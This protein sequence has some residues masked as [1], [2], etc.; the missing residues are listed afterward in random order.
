VVNKI[1]LN[2]ESASH[3]DLVHVQ[4]VLRQSVAVEACDDDEVERTRTRNATV[5][6]EYN[7]S[8]KR[9]MMDDDD[10]D[11][12]GD[13]CSTSSSASASASEGSDDDGDDYDDVDD[14][15][16]DGV[17]G[18]GDSDEI[19]FS[20]TKEES[21]G[22]N[23]S[24][25]QHFDF[26][27]TTPLEILIASV[28]R[29]KKAFNVKKTTNNAK[30]GGKKSK[31]KQQNKKQ[32]HSAK[33]RK[34]A[35]QKM[36]EL[37]IAEEE[38][39]F[40]G[41]QGLSRLGFCRLKAREGEQSVRLAWGNTAEAGALLQLLD[42][43]PNVEEIQEVGLCRLSKE[44]LRRYEDLCGCK[45]PPIGAS[46][47]AIALI[48]NDE[49]NTVERVVVEVKNRSPFYRTHSGY[50]RVGDP[51]LPKTIPAYHV[52]QVQLEM[53][54]ANATSCLLCMRNVTR[55]MAVF[56][57]KR[58]EDYLKRMFQV[59][60]RLY[61]DYV[62][63]D[64]AKPLPENWLAN[65]PVHAELVRRTKEIAENAELVVVLEPERGA[66]F[67]EPFLDF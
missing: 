65:D 2:Q 41:T 31:N 67:E 58:D 63:K 43:Y 5:V 59:I 66:D 34:K 49:T 39:A 24:R 57:V 26:S 47:D 55:G 54:S 17:V 35:A 7:E 12:G 18:K 28:H 45:L 23:N 53:V 56:R 40:G 21:N 16:E 52:P 46:P 48:R 36:R 64:H 30:K 32:K 8:I 51:P 20:R 61:E 62:L 19:F 15:A 13:V 50:Y 4:N 29:Q 44:S 42:N 11:D 25:Q 6:R 27:S 9:E 10:D 33:K 3:R 38:Q 60:G 14:D 37:S 1:G 22:E